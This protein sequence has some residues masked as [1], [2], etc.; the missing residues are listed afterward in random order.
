MEPACG[1]GDDVATT[2][3]H[4]WRGALLGAAVVVAGGLLTLFAPSAAHAADGP[5]SLGGLVNGAAQLVDEALPLPVAGVPSVAEVPVVGGITGAITGGIT[6]A[7]ADAT[8]V[9]TLTDPATTLLDGAV[10]STVGSLP[11]VGGALGEQPI[12]QLVTP[13]PAVLDGIVGAALGSATPGSAVESPVAGVHAGTSV[14]GALAASV[15][16][17]PGAAVAAGLAVPGALM[18]G[19]LMPGFPSG[20]MPLGGDAALPAT[21][22]SVSAAGGP[23]GGPAATVIG[24]GLILLLVGARVRRPTP[25]A[26]LS[27][28]FATDTSPD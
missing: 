24:L 17:R 23:P 25:L 10:G 28:V 18:P 26:P 3:R 8:P 19:A 7:I 11:I 21:P 20:Q 14:I 15:L 12:G 16:L 9:T 5:G 27:P 2:T 22:A 1:V 4:P 6:G 13:L